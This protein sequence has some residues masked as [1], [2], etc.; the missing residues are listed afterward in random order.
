MSFDDIAQMYETRGFCNQVGFGTNP[1]VLIVDMQVAFNDPAHNLGADQSACVNAIQQ[2]LEHAR[3]HRFPICHIKTTYQEDMRDA[4]RWKSKLPA[5]DELRDGTPTVKIDPRLM[6][7]EGEHVIV[8]KFPSSFFG[9]NLVSL[10]VTEAVDTLILTGCSTSGCIR[11]TAI[12][13]V[14]YGFRVIVPEQAVSDRAEAPHR[15]NLFDINAKYGDVVG[16][17]EVL[18]YFDKIGARRIAATK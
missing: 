6:P 18:A 14:S 8:K 7:A 13:G 3:E 12:D 16:L 11:A 15:A 1:G 17:D 5:L 2:L 10:L 9:T 4:G